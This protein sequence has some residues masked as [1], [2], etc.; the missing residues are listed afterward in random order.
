MVSSSDDIK[1][2]HLDLPARR[3]DIARLELGSAVYL[4]GVVYTAREGV[5]KK[6]L[7]DGQAL[8]VDLR[9]LS[10]VNFHCS[11]AAAADGHGGYNVGA[12]TVGYGTGALLGRGIKRVREVHWLDELGIAQAMWLFDVE[13]FGPFIVES[14]L[15]G[16]SLFAQHAEV[17]NAGI[18][19]LYA[20]L[21]PPALH[22]YGETDDRKDEV[23]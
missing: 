4:N 3:E 22:R 23:M 6:V 2:F 13:N 21:K 17:I 5:Y 12:V 9:S 10:N 1:V 20:G 11:P 15:E 19:K 18:E 7:D 14:D 16:N 8:P